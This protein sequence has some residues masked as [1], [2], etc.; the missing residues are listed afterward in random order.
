MNPTTGNLTNEFIEE[1]FWQQIGEITKKIP[2]P[3]A[4]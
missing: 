2:Q 1:L 4:K 3:K